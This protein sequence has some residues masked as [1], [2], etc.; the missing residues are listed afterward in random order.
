M[1]PASHFSIF[2][3]SF[4][5]NTLELCVNS[6]LFPTKYPTPSK[7]SNSHIRIT[8]LPHHTLRSRTLLSPIFQALPTTWGLSPLIT[9][10]NLF[11]DPILRHKKHKSQDSKVD[12][13]PHTNAAAEYFRGRRKGKLRAKEKEKEKDSLFTQTQSLS[14]LPLLLPL[15][16]SLSLSSLLLQKLT[17]FPFFKQKTKIKKLFFPC[18]FSSQ[19][20]RFFLLYIK[21]KQKRNKTYLSQLLFSSLPS[22]P[23]SILEKQ[24]SF[25]SSTSNSNLFPSTFFYRPLLYKQTPNKIEW[26]KYLSSNSF[27]L[28]ILSFFTPF[29][30]LLK[31][32]LF[33]KLIF[34]T[35]LYFLL[36]FML[37]CSFILVF[38]FF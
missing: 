34:F 10:F 17:H 26:Q 15:S 25:Q 5:T 35:L 12:F 23:T 27:Y 19:F 32:I 18:L 38:S 22:F 21:T 8:I 1:R 6:F 33:F 31:E 20:L 24:K 37:F 9:R 28:L 4:F 30:T 3:N 36:Y 16:L 29:L 13:F 7:S 14:S 11:R 2:S